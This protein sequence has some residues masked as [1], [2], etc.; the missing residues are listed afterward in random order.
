MTPSYLNYFQNSARDWHHATKVKRTAFKPY[1]VKYTH[2]PK[3]RTFAKQEWQAKTLQWHSGKKGK[4]Y[5]A[6]HKWRKNYYNKRS[7]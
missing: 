6:Q 7:N 1:I 2:Y 3:A 5:E 4:A